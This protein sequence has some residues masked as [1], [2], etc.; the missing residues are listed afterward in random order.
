MNPKLLQRL[1]KLEPDE[2]C[3]AGRVVVLKVRDGCEKEDADALYADLE[4]A[5]NA[6]RPQDL[7]VLL[8]IINWPAEQVPM[9]ESYRGIVSYGAAA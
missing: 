1:Q 4:A 7:V 3:F 6:V 9:P 5:G 8:R 2:S